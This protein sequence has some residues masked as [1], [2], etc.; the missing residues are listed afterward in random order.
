MKFGIGVSNNFAQLAKCPK[1]LLKSLHPI[2]QP[3]LQLADPRLGP[4]LLSLPIMGKSSYYISDISYVTHITNKTNFLFFKQKYRIK[5][6][7]TI[8]QN[9]YLFPQFWMYEYIPRE[10]STSPWPESRKRYYRMSHF[11]KFFRF[12]GKSCTTEFSTCL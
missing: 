8:F 3:P 2:L 9:N 10:L 11:R 4:P 5:P 6:E 7:L 12:E 1:F